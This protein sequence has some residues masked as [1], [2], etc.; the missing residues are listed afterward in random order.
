MKSLLEIQKEE[1]DKVAEQQQKEQHIKKQQQQQINNMSIATA[2]VW[3]NASNHLLRTSVSAAAPWNV[4]NSVGNSHGGGF[5]EDSGPI[6][7]GSKVQVG[8]M[9]KAQ[10]QRHSAYINNMVMTNNGPTSKSRSMRVRKD[11]ETV[12]KLFEVH[13][14]TVDEFTQWCNETLRSIQATID[15]PTFV[16]FLKDVESP[17]E[18]YDY[19]R[20]YLG[21]S[22]EA[23]NFAKQFLEK[24]SKYR[25]QARKKEEN[26]WGPAPAITPSL[27][28]PQ[29]LSE[30]DGQKAP[31]TKKKKKN[32]M[33][34]V[35]SAIL[36]FTVHASMDRINV[37]D[38]DHVDD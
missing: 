6:T 8:P 18:V 10:D 38:I 14:Q 24:R 21:E 23:H 27:S 9:S 31:G 16:T 33:Q 29:Q 35:D 25:N 26:M 34:K 22:K 7:N 19:A 32:K 4:E 2:G 28:K 12:M 36:G 15:V 11:E 37:G 1:A 13:S 20:V 5:W 17:Y 30:L 3:S